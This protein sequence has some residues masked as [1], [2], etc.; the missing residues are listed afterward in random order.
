MTTTNCFG[1]ETQ[2]N[3]KEL[4]SGL[5]RY[6]RLKTLPVGMKRFKTQAEMEAVPKVRRPKN[7]EK[8]ATDQI[9]GQSRWLGWTVGITMDDLM[10]PNVV[11]LSV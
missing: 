7:G 6:L 5:E 10:G 1:D 11:R 3:F 8:F 9:V 4:V 2:Y